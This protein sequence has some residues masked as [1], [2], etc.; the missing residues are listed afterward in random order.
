MTDSAS[1][2]TF[3]R[4]GRRYVLL[5]ATSIG[6][7]LAPLNSTMI[8]IALPEIRA[9]L[10][11]DH[12][13][14]GWLIS[15][16]LIVM[17]VAQPLGGRLGDQIGRKRVI[18]WA[19]VAFLGFS[20]AS[21]VAPSF[22]VLV[23]FRTGQAIAG[24]AIMPN[25]MAMLRTSLPVSEFGRFNGLHSGVMSTAATS[26][27]LLGAG[28]LAV[29][30]WQAIFL[31]NIPVVLLALVLI[32]TLD[33]SEQPEGGASIDFAGVALLS[34]TLVAVT[35]LLNS[36]RGGRE[37]VIAVVATLGLGVAFVAT[38]RWAARPGVAWHLF[39]LRSFSAA[40]MNV[41]VMNLVMYTTLLSVPFFIQELQ[42]GDSSRT[43]LLLGAMFVM[44]AVTAP[45]SGALAD[46]FGRRVPIFGGSA[47]ALGGAA[48]LVFGLDV[49]ASFSF[50]AVALA[51]VG[52]GVGG[53]SGPATAAAIES[54]S[55]REAGA[56]AG[57]N[58][59]SRYLGS[60]VGAG[61]LAGLLNREAG[62]VPEFD[63]FQIVM[64]LVLAMAAAGLLAATMVHRFPP[65]GIRGGR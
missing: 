52:L 45:I 43:G 4:G 6:A 7:L 35:V 22:W 8:A 19:L 32:Q 48:M 42:G 65:A 57:T 27:P 51:L 34:S 37:A 62:A 46:R 9:D 25:G 12:A 36:L 64:L 29:A 41:A 18:R 56:A 31:V 38:Q 47:I 58:S 21:M 10:D 40:T 39:R 16:Y 30:P 55:V 24:A 54:A 13:S 59:M 44:M 20:L 11:V 28:M 1:D 3:V 50:L 33:Y 26:G 53:S 60:I 17:A 5:T 14:L 2:A 23:L 15:S 63:S 61:A 49:D